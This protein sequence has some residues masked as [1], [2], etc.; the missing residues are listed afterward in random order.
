MRKS[1]ELALQALFLWDVQGDCDLKAAEQIMSDVIDDSTVRMR[2]MQM[3]EAAW[4]IRQTTDASLERLAP[5]WPPRRQPGVDRAI[6]RL[7]VWEITQTGTPPKVVIDEAIELA[8]EF[9]TEQSPAF[10]NGVLDA[11]LRETHPK[12]DTPA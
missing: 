4:A 5:Q 3:A 1:R 2:A 9:S 7:A 6:L 8:K 10:I 11:V 12:T